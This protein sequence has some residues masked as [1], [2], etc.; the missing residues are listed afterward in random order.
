MELVDIPA[1]FTGTDDEAAANYRTHYFGPEDRCYG[2]DSR[3]WGIYA[4]HPCGAQPERVVVTREE[5][6]AQLRRTHDIILLT[7]A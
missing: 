5:Y 3:P 4:L 2:C 1:P 7:L 6:A